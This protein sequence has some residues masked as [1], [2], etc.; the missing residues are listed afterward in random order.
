VNLEQ[1]DGFKLMASEKHMSAE[2]EPA[3]PACRF[4]IVG[5]QNGVAIVGV[6]G[7]RIVV[8]PAKARFDHAPTFMST[9]PKERTDRLGVDVL[10]QHEAHLRDR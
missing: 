1:F 3:T 7:D 8:C 2:R 5:Y 6:G 9:L 10:I 4:R